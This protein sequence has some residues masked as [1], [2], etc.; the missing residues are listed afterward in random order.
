MSDCEIPSAFSETVR[1]ARKQHACC[2][3]SQK[4]SVGE[5]YQYCSGVW[6]GKP[7]SYKTCLSCLKIRENYVAET[8]ECVAFESLRES[9]SNSFYLNYGVKEFIA[10]YPDYNEELK[11]LFNVKD[12]L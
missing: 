8:G 6:D 3:C 2:E 12:D 5:N 7:D 10:D 4:I 11:K 1:K 9:I